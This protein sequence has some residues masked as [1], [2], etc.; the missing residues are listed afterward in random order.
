[1]DVNKESRNVWYCGILPRMAASKPRTAGAHPPVPRSRR[2]PAKLIA[3][4][5]QTGTR[6]ALTTHVNA[7]GD[8]F[9]SEV[10]MLHAL[11][12]LG[13]RAVITNPTPVPDRYKFLLEGVETAEKTSAAAK[14]VEKADVVLVLDISDLARLGHLGRA[15]KSS[16]APVACI[17]HHVTDGSLPDGPRMVDSTACATGELIYD[18]LRT[19][20]MEITPAIAR[21]LYV[22]IMTD[23]GGF[24][25][26]NTTART[27]HVAGDLVDLGVDPEEIYGQVYAR[28]PKGR[29]TLIAEVLDTL[30]VEDEI[31]LAW[32]TI[33]DGALE[34]HEVDSE[35]L[36][37]IVEFPRSIDGMKLALQFRRIAKGR[38]KISFRSVGPVDAAA[39]AQQFGGG[40]HRKAAGASLPGSLAEVQEQ[41]LKAARLILS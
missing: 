36:D 2:Q 10:A 28:N 27:L 21:A 26:S 38:V 34:R 33:P 4:A 35:E 37:G 40:G 18:F 30:V 32:I 6:V 5:F 11:T 16:G 8:G 7:D 12:A 22:A 20:Q 39:L 3:S 1:M 24:R 31:G 15:V 14:H 19:N 17:D 9:G 41:V 25:F 23:T 13:A 29:V